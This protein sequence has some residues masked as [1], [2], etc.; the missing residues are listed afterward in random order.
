MSLMSKV[1][2]SEK[3]EIVKK[4]KEYQKH[5]FSVTTG[6]ITI[7]NVYRW[8]DILAILMNGPYCLTTSKMIDRIVELIDPGDE[9]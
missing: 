6:H 5:G 1:S 2:D 4:L 3:R 8:S 9:E 7:S